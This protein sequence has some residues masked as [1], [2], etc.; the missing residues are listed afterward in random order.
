MRSACAII[1]SNFDERH[2]LPRQVGY[3]VHQGAPSRR[4][5][6]L[7]PFTFDDAGV[8][9]PS[10]G[11]ISTEAHPHGGRRLDIDD[12]T[13]SQGER[14]RDTACTPSYIDYDIVRFNI[15]R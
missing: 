5:V 1:P 10:P 6:N 3:V 11:G 4:C 2:D 15:R 7:R 14:Q 9:D 13:T 8:A 12:L